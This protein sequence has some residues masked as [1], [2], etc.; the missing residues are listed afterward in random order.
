MHTVED[1]LLESVV[2]DLLE[3]AAQAFHDELVARLRHFRGSD[4]VTP[5]DGCYR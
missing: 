1:T 3:K 2:F 4:N 5:L